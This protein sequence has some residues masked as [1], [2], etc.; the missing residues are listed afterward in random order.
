M[1]AKITIWGYGGETIA[2]TIPRE[3]YEYFKENEYDF[4]EYASYEYQEQF[5]ELVPEEM[6]PFPPGEVHECDDVF[7][8][9]GASLDILT[10]ITVT[11][12]NGDE[13]WSVGA[14]KDHLINLGVTVTETKNIDLDDI[15][16]DTVIY[17]SGNG[18]KGNFFGSEFELNGEFDPKK[19]TVFYTTCHGWSIIEGIEYDG[20]EFEDIGD[21]DTR[22]KWAD[23]EL[24]VIGDIEEY[25]PVSLDDR[26]EE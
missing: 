11:D 12:E 18:E 16:E 22:G 26:D 2:G 10:Q 6:Q 15:E 4:D 20:Y 24:I 17:W 9:W 8:E 14:D 23:S 19:L 3:I 25:D 21:M 1:K 5:M 7:H 13:I